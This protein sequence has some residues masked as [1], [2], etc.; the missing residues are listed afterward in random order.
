MVGAGL[1]LESAYHEM[2]FSKLLIFGSLGAWSW[3]LPRP[4]RLVH[5]GMVALLCGALLFNKY[6]YRNQHLVPLG[7]GAYL[8]S[9][10]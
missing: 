3:T 4:L 9:N 5:L 2:F 8:V 6:H 7:H 1:Y 10:K